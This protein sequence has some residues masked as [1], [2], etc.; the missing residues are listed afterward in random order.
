MSRHT[1]WAGAAASAVVAVMAAL[2]LA[3]V[4]SADPDPQ[5]VFDEHLRLAALPSVVIR[6]EG[7]DDPHAADRLAEWWSATVDPDT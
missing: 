6:M 7:R 1:L 2:A 5:E 4:A 3:P